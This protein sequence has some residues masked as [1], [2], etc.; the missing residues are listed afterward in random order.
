MD[1]LKGQRPD[2]RDLPGAFVIIPPSSYRGTEILWILHL[3]VLHS[4]V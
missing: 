4:P 3:R 2:S 1:F